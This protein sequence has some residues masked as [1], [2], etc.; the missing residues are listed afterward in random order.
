[1]DSNIYF[2]ILWFTAGSE[3][4]KNIRILNNLKARVL[5]KSVKMNTISNQ[6]INWKRYCPKKF[7]L[8]SE[9]YEFDEYKGHGKFGFCC[10][11]ESKTS[12][13]KVAVKIIPSNNDQQSE[14]FYKEVK[15]SKRLNHRNIVEYHRTMKV[16]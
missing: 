7:T 16:N 2:I 6:F 5:Q 8:N 13:K 11:F 15:M 9:L 4:H 10:S 3:L 14:S 1:M 12:K